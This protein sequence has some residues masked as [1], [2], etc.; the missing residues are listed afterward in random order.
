[1]ATPNDPRRPEMCA[2]E[3]VVYHGDN[4]VAAATVAVLERRHVARQ[5]TAVAS[6]TQLLS[7]LRHGADVAVV[8][9]GGDDVEELFEALGYRDVNTPVLVVV[10]SAAGPTR[11]ARVL[12]H[13]AAGVVLE[14]SPPE[15]LCRALAEIGSSGLVMPDEIR[16]TV[17]DLLRKRQLRRYAARRRLAALSPAERRV[18]LALTEGL[19]VTEIAKHLEVSSYTIRSHV[20]ALGS[21]LGARGQLRIAATGRALFGAARPTAWDVAAVAVDR[22][23]A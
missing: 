4:L 22:E 13:G 7:S 19:S 10:D 9:D 15:S 8:Y 1:M 23:G 14:S 5:V 18:L 12:E 21:K 17:L 16:V 2:D 20:R 3:I 6:L 11:A